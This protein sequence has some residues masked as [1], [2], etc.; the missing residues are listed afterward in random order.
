MIKTAAQRSKFLD[1]CLG[2]IAGYA[3]VI[4]RATITRD[5]CSMKEIFQKLRAH[6]GFSKSGSSILDVT[7][8]K[9]RPEESPESLYQ[10]ILTLVDSTLLCSE[11][12]ISHH[13]ETPVVDEERTPAVENLVICIWLKALHPSLP[14]LVKQRFAT[15]LRFCTLAS[16]REEISGSM[17][18]LLSELG[19]RD[20]PSGPNAFQ[21]STFR[22]NQRFSLNQPR[23]PNT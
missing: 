13:G 14:Q 19:E 6:Y 7:S 23:F 8:I 21:V 17:S 20:L 12:D 5:C 16:I 2:Q 22:P 3:T 15:D 4:S 18:E 9:R 1:I 10:R 11:E